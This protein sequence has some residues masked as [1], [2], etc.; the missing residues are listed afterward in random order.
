MP[1]LSSRGSLLC[2]GLIRSRSYPLGHR[3]GTLRRRLRRG[4][5]SGS[6]SGQREEGATSWPSDH[7]WAATIDRI[8]TGWPGVMRIV[9]LLRSNSD[10]GMAWTSLGPLVRYLAMNN[11]Y[12]F[13]LRI[14]RI[15]AVD[16]WSKRGHTPIP[17]RPSEFAKES[18]ECLY[19]NSSST[20][21]KNITSRSQFLW[22]RP[23]VS[24]EIIK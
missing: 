2:V 8:H 12:R 17:F 21:S 11:M 4:Q 6:T 10:Q 19:N 23:Q 5:P 7:I 18:P 3:P 20:G 24:R 14:D 15:V 9:H 22:V 16:V 13:K 1:W